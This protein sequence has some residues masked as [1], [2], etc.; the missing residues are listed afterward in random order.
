MNQ[1]LNWT[2]IITAVIGAVIGIVAG[3]AGTVFQFQGRL[4]SVEGQLQR[5]NPPIAHQLSVQNPSTPSIPHQ[6]TA[7]ASPV[8]PVQK[9]STSSLA[10]GSCFTAKIT[11]PKGTHDRKDAT[12]YRIRGGEVEVSWDIPEC[13]MVV[14]YY[15]GNE[16]K[17]RYQNTRS[18][19]KI[20]I[21]YPNKIGE[22]ETEIRLLRGG[23]SQP[24]D[25]I[26]VWVSS[27][28][29]RRW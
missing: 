16:L 19:Q 1:N 5:M 21:G 23:S 25:S 8:T 7:S 11:D 17:K 18:G 12:A 29:L 4:S 28:V 13:I 10:T 27:S 6:P 26:W 15:Q 20:F 14:E 22:E 24:S 9:P 2:H 3:V